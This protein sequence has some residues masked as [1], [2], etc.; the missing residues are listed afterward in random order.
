MM[1]GS[2]VAMSIY[3]CQ[4]VPIQTH[5]E[6]SL[7]KESPVFHSIKL[8]RIIKWVLAG[9]SVGVWSSITNFIPILNNMAGNIS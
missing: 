2:G 4:M 6:F 3:G 1:Q 7:S 8:K 9:K 5:T